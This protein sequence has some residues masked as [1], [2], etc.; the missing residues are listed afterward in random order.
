M[1]NELKEEEKQEEFSQ[2]CNAFWKLTY[3]PDES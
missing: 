1:S 2:N 3:Q